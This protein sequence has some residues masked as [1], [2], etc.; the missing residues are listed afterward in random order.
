MF[1]RLGL[2]IAL[3]RV[4]LA[5]GV[6]TI[7]STTRL[8]NVNVVVT[9]HK[10]NLIED[11]KKE[12]FQVSDNGSPVQIDFFSV[13]S[14]TAGAANVPQVPADAVS[15]DFQ[16]SAGHRAITVILFDSVNTSFSDLAYARKQVVQFLMQ[17]R[18][19]DHV[20]LYMLGRELRI[21]NEFT[22]DAGSLLEKIAKEGIAFDVNPPVPDKLRWTFSALEAI[23]HHLSGQPGRKNLIWVSSSFPLVYVGGRPMPFQVP[24]G[25]MDTL[26]AE[27]RHATLALNAVDIAVYPVDARGLSAA[28]NIGMSHVTEARGPV[29]D[30]WNS[31][32]P[33][34]AGVP[35]PAESKPFKTSSNVGTMTAFANDTGGKAF[36]DNSDLKDAIRR[37]I[38]G[39]RVSYSLGFYPKL[40]QGKKDFHTISVRVNRRGVTARYRRGY[41][42][43]TEQ[44]TPEDSIRAVLASPLEATGLGVMARARLVET[45]KIAAEV[46][47]DA[48]GVSVQERDGKRIITLDVGLVPMD[49]RGTSYAAALKTIE[50]PFN[51]PAY[52]A[53]LQKG[54]LY[55]RT[56]D[57]D[58]RAREL[59]IVVRDRLGGAIGS[60]T[61]P[62]G[63]IQRDPALQ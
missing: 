43:S 15:N 10:G 50:V 39:S 5:Q 24:K 8:V 25:I 11:L 9:D 16:R 55:R 54:L 34:N 40:A 6:P 62:A 30:P 33:W 20:G 59:R 31:S 28:P 29:Y 36:F 26:N 22:G 14:D 52:E 37:V 60:V 38:D 2:V 46:H 19:A 18:P 63:K 21:L 53:F 51:Q 13:E 41:F 44:S 57:F 45:G 23:A 3:A 58:P 32:D 4:L 61:L 1:L 35:T 17:I 7:R 27:L 48:A 47:V 12:D 49:A 56:L 42:D